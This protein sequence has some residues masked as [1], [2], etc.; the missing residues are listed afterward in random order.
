ML[1][2]FSDT[3][4]QANVMPEFKLHNRQTSQPLLQPIERLEE[5][6]ENEVE[7]TNLPVIRAM[8]RLSTP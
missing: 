8:N 5:N 2:F 1:R 7:Q 3:E 6:N 4:T